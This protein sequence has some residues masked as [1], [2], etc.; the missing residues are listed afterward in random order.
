MPRQTYCSPRSS[1]ANSTS[2]PAVQDMRAE[3]TEWQ[4][5]ARAAGPGW[6]VWRWEEVDTERAQVT[7]FFRLLPPG[8][9]APDV[10]G[11]VIQP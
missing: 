4:A 3:Q 5:K 1:A 2:E 9:D 8:E 11:T 7:F 10:W 6:R